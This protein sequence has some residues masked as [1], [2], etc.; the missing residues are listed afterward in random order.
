MMKHRLIIVAVVLAPMVICAMAHAKKAGEIQDSVY[1]DNLYGLTFIIPSGWEASIKTDKSP[2]RVVLKHKD[3]E[4]PSMMEPYRDYITVPT[5]TII[6]DTTSLPVDSFVD[7]MLDPDFKSKQKKFFLKHLKA[8]SKPFELVA[9]EDKA[10]V[11]F[12]SVEIGVVQPYTI[13]LP[14]QGTNIAKDVDA[15]YAGGLYFVAHKSHIYIFHGICDA[16][17]LSTYEPIWSSLFRRLKIE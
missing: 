1:S 14:I 12:S 8:I 5:F 17:M 15:A 16:Q 9:R 11:L 2:V 13:S 3:F 4:I 7:R 10:E 6:V